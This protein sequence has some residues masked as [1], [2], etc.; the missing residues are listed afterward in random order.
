[1]RPTQRGRA[2][3]SRVERRD[4]RERGEDRVAVVGAAA[5]VEPA[6]LEHRRPR[7]EARAPAGHLG[8]LVEV[9]V[10]QHGVAASRP[11]VAGMSK[12]STGVRPSRRTTS[13]ARPLTPWRAAQR[14]RLLRPR[15]RCGRAR[16]HSGR[17]AATWRAGG[18]SRRA[19]GRCRRP[20]GECD[21]R[22]SRAWGR[23]R[24]A[25]GHGISSRCRH[26]TRRIPRRPCL[27]FLAELVR[28]LARRLLRLG[29]G[30]DVDHPAAAALAHRD[31][32]VDLRLHR[33]ARASRASTTWCSG[34]GACSAARVRYGVAR[35]RSR[36]RSQ[37]Y[38]RSSRLRR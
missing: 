7:P 23:V 24:L 15:P 2:M 11:P 37:E 1:M 9:A 35:A 33:A 12:K 34:R 27:V 30:R 10:E 28:D 17:S 20:I 4:G 13:S 26:F 14:V 32:L 5:A 16:F 6:V 22:G 19:A 3:P 31:A 38:L 36:A 8:L 29:A 21:R 18:C 25:C